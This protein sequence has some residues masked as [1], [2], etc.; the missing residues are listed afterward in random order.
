[1]ENNWQDRLD[2]LLAEGKKK[3]S[4]AYE[5][6]FK[7]L[8]KGGAGE[9]EIRSAME[10]L[11]QAGV[12]VVQKSATREWVESIVIAFILAMFIREFF[13]QA[14]RIP[15]G[16][17]RPTL[18]VGDRILVTKLAY[19]PKLRFTDKRLPG[20]GKP[21]RGDIIVFVYPE[22]NKKDFIK[23]LIAF[24]GETVQ[25]RD[26]NVYINGKEVE[27]PLIKNRY[28][29]NYGP[30]AQ[31]GEVI[32]VPEGYYFVLGDNSAS[33]SDSRYWGFVPEQN[34]IGKAFLIYW[35]PQRIRLLK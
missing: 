8:R 16:S 30:L 21:Q 34:V 31:P 12:C 23:R 17:M 22:N 4:L 15:S 24:G 20:F 27:N 9:K 2:K 14:F 13:V 28:Y 18:A 11:A 10:T 35:P 19:G 1:M 29:Y 6:V 5:K 33:S 3:K 25:I 26:G 32:K 7:S